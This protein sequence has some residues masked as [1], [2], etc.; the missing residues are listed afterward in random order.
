MTDRAVVSLIEDEY[1]RYKSLGERALD[2]LDPAQLS[3]SE[4]DRNSVATLVWHIAGTS[5]RA[6]PTF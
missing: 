5:N 4:G 3:V 6:S 1:R 2:Q